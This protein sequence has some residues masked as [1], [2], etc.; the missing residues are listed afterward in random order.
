MLDFCEILGF[1]TDETNRM[2]DFIPKGHYYQ[3][4]GM[5]NRFNQLLEKL[6]CADCGEILYPVDTSHFAAHTVVRFYCVNTNCSNNDEIYLNDCLNRQCNSVIDSRVS[7]KC[8]NGLYICDMCGSCCSHAML[9]RRLSNLQLTGGRVHPNLIR[10]VDEKL[11]HLERAEYFCY[12]CGESMTKKT[13]EVFKC[14]NCSVEYKT[15]KFKI[16]GYI[17]NWR[18]WKGKRLYNK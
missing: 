5:V 6:Y 3:F 13:T 15:A 1:N 4:I 12:K 17:S 16:K 8:S 10:C 11:G 9:N 18:T 7:K 14:E 2:G